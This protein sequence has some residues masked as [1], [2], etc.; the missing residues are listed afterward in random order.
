MAKR[1]R[2]PKHT[3]S[4]QKSNQLGKEIQVVILI[5]ISIVLGVLIYSKTGYIGENLSP[6]LRWNNRLGK[7]YCANWYIC[8]G[9]ADSS[10]WR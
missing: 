8:Y 4:R 7:I 3:V 1:G 2:K 9:S 5:V 6:F 10:R